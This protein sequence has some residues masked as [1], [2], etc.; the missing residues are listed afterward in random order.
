MSDFRDRFTDGMITYLH[1]VIIGKMM[2]MEG[3]LTKEDVKIAVQQSL[4][5]NNQ[6]IEQ[7]EMKI[8]IRC[9]VLDVLKYAQC[10]NDDEF[11][12]YFSSLL[13]NLHTA[14]ELYQSAAKSI[15][16]FCKDNL[17]D[18]LDAN[19]ETYVSR[20]AQEKQNQG[21]LVPM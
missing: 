12:T 10:N 17:D 18:F 6:R 3:N 19:F 4:A 2:Y 9:M 7:G 11:I 16:E 13:P 8:F 14:A 1:G 5:D 21:Y 20:A 15:N